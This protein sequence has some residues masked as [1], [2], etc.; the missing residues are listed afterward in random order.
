MAF[1][2]KDLHLIHP[3]F[4]A[5]SRLLA[6]YYRQN[7]KLPWDIF[8]DSSSR[9]WPYVLKRAFLRGSICERASFRILDGRQ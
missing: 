4:A 2:L 3:C 5:F 1:S 9:R 8:R 7:S 6:F